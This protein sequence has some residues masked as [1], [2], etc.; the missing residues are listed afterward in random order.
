[1]SQIKNATPKIPGSGRSAFIN[2]AQRSSIRE[3]CLFIMPSS[4]SEQDP[5]IREVQ[6]R[7]KRVSTQMIAKHRVAV[8]IKA[9]ISAHF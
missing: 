2:A 5:S 7:L 1:M 8:I 3:Y 9:G 6:Y 4:L